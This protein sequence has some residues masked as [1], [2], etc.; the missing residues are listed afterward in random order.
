MGQRLGQHFLVNKGILEKIADAASLEQSDAVL[1]IGPGRGALTFEL[2][3]RAGHVVAVEK[4]GVLSTALRAELVRR[5]LRNVDIITDDIRT[6]LSA[7]HAL[8]TQPYKVVANIP[9]YLTSALIRALLEHERPPSLIILLIQKEVAERIVARKDKESILSLSV[10]FY[11]QPKLLFSVS[12]GSFSPPP[13]V[14]SAVIALKPTTHASTVS[15]DA[16][17]RVVKAGFSAPRKTL[18]GNLVAKLNIGR[19]HVL[20]ALETAGISPTARAED[21]E[22]SHWELLTKALTS[23]IPQTH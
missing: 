20:A 15:A 1:E 2:A 5:N 16:F 14:D 13:R 4:D 6:F 23:S 11:A 17:F 10:K 19:D 3:T 12:A 21:V 18:V 9:Y 8:F 22:L 7:N